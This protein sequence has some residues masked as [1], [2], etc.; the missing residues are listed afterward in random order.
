MIE[1]AT[2]TAYIDELDYRLARS[3]YEHYETSICMMLHMG[4]FKKYEHRAHFQ[5]FIDN[6]SSNSRVIDTND[7]NGCVSEG[8]NG[9]LARIAKTFKCKHGRGLN[10]PK[11]YFAKLLKQIANVAYELEAYGEHRLITAK[12]FFDE[13]SKD[14][15][16][17]FKI[18]S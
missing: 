13:T 6:Q 17:T 15:L 10:L 3:G 12:L 7:F 2:V 9:R 18:I 4:N 16:V 11:A 1:I 14:K 5:F 8:E